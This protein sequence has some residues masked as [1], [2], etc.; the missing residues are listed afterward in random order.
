[1][2]L[3][4]DAPAGLWD[5]LAREVTERG[6]RL[7]R[8]SLDDL[9]GA[10][11]LTNLT[12]REVWVRHDV[13]PAQAVKTLA[14]ELGHILLHTQPEPAS[15]TGS[16]ATAARR[17]GAVDPAEGWVSCAGVRE[18]E[19]ESVAYLVTAAHGL[20]S[21]AY[22]FPYVASWASGP[23]ATEGVP[24]GDIVT[25]TG[26]RVMRAAGQLIDTTPTAPTPSPAT[27]ALAAR[28]EIT[29]EHRSELREQ[30]SRAVAITG[31]VWS[32]AAPCS[33]SSPTATSSSPGNIGASWVPGYLAGRGLAPALEQVPFGYA[34][35]GW[36]G[37]VDHLARLGYSDAQI[38]A[39]GMASRARTGRLVDRF[40]DRLILPVHDH[41]GELVGFVGRLGPDAVDD[42]YSPRYLNSPATPL[43]NKSEVLFGLGGHAARIQAGSQPV[44]CEGPLD[45]VAVDVAAARTGA[46]DGRGRGVRD[47]VHHAARRTVDRA[48][49]GPSDLSRPRRRP[50]RA[51][52]HRNGVAP[53]HRPRSP[54]GHRRRAARRHRSRRPGRR[55]PRHA[56]AD[57]VRD[58]PAGR[59]GGLRQH[60]GRGR[61][62][63]QPGPT[64]RRVPSAAPR[65]HHGSR[66]TSAPTTSGTSP[67]G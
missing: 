16:P 53:A 39:A 46:A 54:A 22:T 45:A 56:L 21:D 47:R 44:L 58:G 12:T 42:R 27:A 38:E 14:H 59:P 66:P 61:P 43:F 36:T 15:A 24:I 19:A 8:G 25:R 62:G 63:R 35:A 50:G 7:R 10:N 48:G 20:D 51:A 17:H 28:A 65:H 13:Q 37:L 18:V 67:T 5:A 29:A 6:Y 64:T 40:R 30:T 4:G 11:G 52:R 33:A 49:R 31:T 2:L 26:T 34:P 3:A 55:R 60:P 9:H 57:L 23:A 32:S 1:M 41:A